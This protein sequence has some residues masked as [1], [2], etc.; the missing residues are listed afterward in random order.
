[1]LKNHTSNLTS[2]RNVFLGDQGVHEVTK[3]ALALLVRSNLVE[4]FKVDDD[5]GD[6][7]RLSPVLALHGLL[8][9][10]L[11]AV[12]SLSKVLVGRSLRLLV[13]VVVWFFLVVEFVLG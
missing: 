13:V 1:M 2:E 4:F 8:L 6:D 7:L 11:E 9:E 5:C 3:H 10:V 12:W